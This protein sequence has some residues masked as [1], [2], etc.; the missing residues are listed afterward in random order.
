MIFEKWKEERIFLFIMVTFGFLIMFLT[1]PM[2]TPDEN[3]HFANAVSI[4][5]GNIL[6]DVKDGVEGRYLSEEINQFIA[7]NNGRYSGKLSEKYTFGENY[8][9][10]WLPD[11]PE[12]LVFRSMEGLASINPSAYLVAGMG[13]R[14]GSLWCK[15]WG[16]GYVKPYNLLIFGRLFNAVFYML[17]GYWALKIT[18]IL[19]R[20][21]LV[22]LLMPMSIYLGVSISYDAVIIPVCVLFFANTFRLIL[23]EEHKAVTNGDILITLMCTF[24]MIGIKT[25]YAPFLALLLFIPKEKFGNQKKYIGCIA[26]TIMTALLVYV[27]YK[28]IL[29]ITMDGY[30]AVE[31]SAVK[32]QKAYFWS[33]L[34]M[35]PE[36]ASQTL[37]SYKIFYMQGFLA[38]LGQLDTNFILPFISAFYTLFLAIMLIDICNIE[39]SVKKGIRALALVLWAVSIGGTFLNM[40]L[41]W[42]PK[43]QEIGGN[44]VSGVQGRYFIPAFLFSCVPFMN[45]ILLKSQRWNKRLKTVSVLFS[46]ILVLNSAVWTSVIL[47]L[48]Y[49]C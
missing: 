43:V 20:T 48:R 46:E 49:W 4:G 33:H 5:Y 28:A 9:D 14:L 19:K 40:Y 32:E 30:Q 39:V 23:S 15:F 38:K 24:F 12:K 1:P 11:V 29:S 22:L 6:P 25:A 44:V 16:E 31:N 27:G 42:T 7:S 17:V 47:L 41:K 8:F 34:Y 36:I 26:A 21:M 2:C 3:T 13:I 18:P 10:S 37:K 35:I 45:G